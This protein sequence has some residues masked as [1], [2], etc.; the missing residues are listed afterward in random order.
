MVITVS[1]A[2]RSSVRPR[3]AWLARRL[4]SNLNGLV[5]TA[6]VSAPS[7]EAR[8]AITGAAPV[9]VPPPR[10][11]VTKTMSASDSTSISLSVSS[12]AAR[13]PMSGSAPAPSPLVS[14]PPI[15]IRVGA[16]LLASAWRSVLATMN[17]TPS[18]PVRTMRLTALPPP[19]PTP[20][21]LM[22]APSRRASSSLSR[23][24]STL[25]MVSCSWSV[26]VSSFMEIALRRS[27][28]CVFGVR[29]ANGYPRKLWNMP[30]S[31]TKARANAPPEP[32]RS[33]CAWFRCAY[34]TS[35][36][37]VAHSGVLT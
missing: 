23:S 34:I 30:R 20:I 9:P 24:G 35:P 26:R 28:S 36:T 37:A 12:S 11:V 19:P 1:T 18:S 14:L 7:S 13:R 31:R 10:P 21:T 8:P 15:W 3:S 22:R 2:S 16:A 29:S 25:T 5:T 4:P 27:L 32:A 17:S 33:R 6:I